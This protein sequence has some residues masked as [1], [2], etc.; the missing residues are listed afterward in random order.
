[1]LKDLF[2]AP[3]LPSVLLLGVV[4]RTPGAAIGFRPTAD[5]CA[6][7]VERSGGRTF[8]HAFG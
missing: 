1:M 4:A 8:V 6:W 3:I 2:T 5:V 7:I